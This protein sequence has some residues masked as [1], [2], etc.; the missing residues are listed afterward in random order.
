[1]RRPDLLSLALL[2]ASSVAIAPFAGCGGDDTSGGGGTA[3]TST[4]TTST[5][6]GPGGAG[7]EGGSDGAGGAGGGATGEPADHLLISEVV[8]SRGDGEYIEIWNPTNAAVDLTNY[9]LSDNSVYFAIADGDPWMPAGSPGTDFLLQ[10]PAG[11]TLPADGY[12]VLATDGGFEPIYQRCADFA[13]ADTPIPCGGASVPPMLTPEN[14]AIGT[15]SG[16]LFTNDGEM[17]VLFQWDGTL[18]SPVKDVDYITWGVDNPG[19]SER[20]DKTGKAGYQPDTERSV[21]RAAPAPIQDQSLA[22][23][24]AREFGE[25]LTDGNGVSGHDETSER[26]DL[27]FVSDASPTPGEKNSCATQ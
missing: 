24:D 16:G 18:G 13:L 25:I 21:Q 12:L 19:N 1:M 17:I 4:T 6:S 27:S 23:C 26:F 20:A 9:Y 2:A 22:R 5:T 11:T 3:S 15:V 8:V 14:G 7:G 10:F